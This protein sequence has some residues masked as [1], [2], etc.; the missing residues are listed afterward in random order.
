MDSSVKQKIL[1]VPAWWPCSFFEEQQQ[2]YANQYE[3]L[4]LIGEVKF[5]RRRNLLKFIK[6]T[7]V[8]ILKTDDMYRLSVDWFRFSKKCNLNRQFDKL[9]D[10]VGAQIIQVFSGEKPAMVHVQSISDISVFV[11]FW[12]KNNNIPLFVTEHILY[13]RRQFDYFT[14][15]KEQVYSIA[16]RVYCVSNYLLRN[17]ITN[18]FYMKYANVIGNIVSKPAEILVT[19]DKIRNDRVMFVAGHLHDKEFDILLE[20]ASL[21]QQE[22]VQFD[23]Y[24]L[25]GSDKYENEKTIDQEIEIRKITNLKMQGK[26]SHDQMLK[27]YAGYSVLLSTSVSETFGLAVAEA[28]ASGVPVV[29][30]DSGGIRDFVN[31]NNGV[32]VNIR[33]VKSIVWAVKYVLNAKFDY[34]MMS[35]NILNKYDI[36]S[37]K[38]RLYE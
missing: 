8:R 6:K 22:K 16:Q 13:I 1:F 4:N 14:Q 17:L 29:C 24:G 36:L 20:V 38:R 15:K 2:V 5:E 18:G 9:V 27:K 21:L 28:I 7:H 10:E 12:A 3:I 35:N 19:N 33:D 11:A 32:I 37:Y 26:F 31:E 25:N 30:T 34:V 23:V